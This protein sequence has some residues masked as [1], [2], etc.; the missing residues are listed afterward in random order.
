MFTEVTNETEKIRVDNFRKV[1]HEDFSDRPAF[2]SKKSFARTDFSDKDIDLIFGSITDNII[3]P[4]Y[5]NK[6]DS[7]LENVSTEIFH[8]PNEIST[9]VTQ[10]SFSFI[11]Q[12]HNKY[13][14]AQIKSGLMIID[15][16][17]A[18]ERILYE[19]AMKRLDTDLP[20]TQQLLFSITQELDPGTF[21]LLK[22]VEPYLKKLGYA[23]KFSTK[24]KITIEGVPDDIKPGFEEKILMEILDEYLINQ[25][26]KELE[27]RDNIAKSY[28]CK[29]AIKAGD[30][31]SES[32]MKLLIDKLFATSMPY[33]CPH[34][35]PIVVKISLNEFDRRFGRT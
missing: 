29:T 14:L 7:P 30:K 13:I 34:G 21:A 10:N 6:T 11:F 28:S 23:L 8:K 18:H 25:R 33:V 4:A 5:T 24:N 26:E 1:E 19:K 9:E 3:K 22:E 15:Q 32:E 12:L 35:R 2:E 27:T 16:H 31:L 20:F 17:V